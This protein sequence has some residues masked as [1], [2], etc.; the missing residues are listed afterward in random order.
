MHIFPVINCSDAASA[1]KRMLQAETFLRAGD[2]VHVDV[3]DG[4]FT[5]HKTWRDMAG[6][7]ALRLPFNLEVHLMVEHPEKQI[8]PWLAIG[9]KRFVVHV[10]TV[11]E[12]SLEEI[13]RKCSARG[14]ERGAQ[15][16][17]SSNPETPAGEFRPY[18]HKIWFY[19]VL[20][21]HPGLAGQKFLP[22][23]LEK[24]KFLRKHAPDGIIIEVDGGIRPGTAKLAKE[25]GAD[26]AVSASYIFESEDMRA[27]F[28]RLM[29]V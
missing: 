3:A 7:A 6:W 8:E 28:E 21:V 17:L 22:R 12:K 19:Q 23:T 15:V 14:S 5:F 26:I 2:F 24:V 16:M 4:I 20:C 13:L 25:A 18:F 27:A 9:A 11:T 1:R 10:E 29:K